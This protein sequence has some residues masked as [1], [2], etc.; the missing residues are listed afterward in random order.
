M[1]PRRKIRPKIPAGRPL[2][3]TSPI[4]T[5]LGTSPGQQTR[6]AVSICQNLNLHFAPTYQPTPW[7]RT[8]KKPHFCLWIRSRSPL[9]LS[10]AG[11]LCPSVKKKE[12]D[13]RPTRASRPQIPHFPSSLALNPPKSPL[14]T[15]WGS[16]PCPSPGLQSPPL[17]PGVHFGSALRERLLRPPRRSSGV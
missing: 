14:E 10:K 1:P 4:P 13:A 7:Q 8:P 6:S 12:R 9:Q 3:H 15:H 5:G 11:Q 2:P 16:A 17:F